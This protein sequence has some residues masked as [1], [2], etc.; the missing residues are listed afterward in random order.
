MQNK[1]TRVLATLLLLLLLA[2]LIAVSI[3][4]VD[5]WTAEIVA[6]KKLICVQVVD[7]LEKSSEKYIDSLNNSGVFNRNTLTELLADKVDTDLKRI[8]SSVLSKSVG[9]EGGFYFPQ[10]GKFLGYDYPTSPPPIPVYGPP[11]RSYD[12]ILEQLQVCLENKQL[13]TKLHQFDPAIFPL[14][15][16]PI[17]NKGIV[18]GGIWARVHI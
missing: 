3:H 16:K 7:S 8:T 15:T 17:I 18:V 1:N 13:V 14:S 12:I 9:M 5:S 10:I 11:P 4:F 6:S 2:A